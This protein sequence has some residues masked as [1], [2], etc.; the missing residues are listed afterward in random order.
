MG[1]DSVGG[2]VPVEKCVGLTCAIGGVGPL[3]GNLV[4]VS[5]FPEL[6][7]QAH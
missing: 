7:E 5:H 2:N 4:I 6:L 1:Y 3:T